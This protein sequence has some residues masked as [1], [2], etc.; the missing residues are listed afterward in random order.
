M[1]FV[2]GLPKILR[3]HDSILV[4]VDH[5]SKMAHFI[6]Y[7]KTFDASRVAKL[8]FNE[9][10]RLHGLPKIIVSDWDVKFTSYFWKTLWHQVGT[11]LQYSS[12]FQPK[13]TVKLK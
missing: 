6:P 7:S 12:A 13:L 4:V 9:F 1:D 5:F 11:K 3:K 10:V 8:V 2:L